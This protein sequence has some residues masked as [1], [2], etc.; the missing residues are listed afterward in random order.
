MSSALVQD[1]HLDFLGF[2]NRKNE[3]RAEAQKPIFMGNHEPSD[4]IRQYGE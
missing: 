1:H 4:F 3:L 2:A